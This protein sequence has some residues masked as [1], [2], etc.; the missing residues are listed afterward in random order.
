M[1]S[2]KWLQPALSQLEAEG[3]MRSSRPLPTELIDLCSNDYLGYAAEAVSRETLPVGRAGAGASRLVS[4]NFPA[5]EQLESTLAQWLQRDAALLFSSGYAANTGTIPALVGPEDAVFSDQFNH[6]SII[7]GC[8]L[9]GAK[10]HVYPHL[11]LDVLRQQLRQAQGFRRL[12]L[13]SESYF[14]MDGDGP[15]LAE[16]AGLCREFEAMWLL[17]EAHALGVFGPCGA[18]RAAEAGVEPDILVGTFGKALGA[19]GAF[20]ASS[21]SMRAWLWNRARS[22]VFSTGISPL[23]AAVVQQNVQRA[24]QDEAARTALQGLCRG[25]GERLQPLNLRL[26]PAQF[27]PIF[28]IILGTSEHALRASARLRE[29]GFQAPAI[30]PPT[31]P[32]GTAR[33]RITLNARMDP[34]LLDRVAAELGAACE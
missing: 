19:Q 17:D 33:L 24:R 26:P 6:A 3:L 2:T 10:I 8:R 1:A 14:S 18:G 30:R 13:V 20:V 9:S 21:E 7:D 11:R 12:L 5:H 34:S 27:G 4:G 25:F 22:F 29:A 31:V 23:L 15:D 28:P 32:Q 16:L